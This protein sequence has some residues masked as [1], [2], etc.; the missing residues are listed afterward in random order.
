MFYEHSKSFCGANVTAV[1]QYPGVPVGNIGG[2]DD[3]NIERCFFVAGI[4]TPQDYPDHKRVLK[5]GAVDPVVIS[6]VLRDL[7]VLATKG[8]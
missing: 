2:W 1:V 7:T 6:E 3:Q 4:Y 5:L 8:K